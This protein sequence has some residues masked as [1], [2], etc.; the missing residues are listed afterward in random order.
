MGPRGRSR[1][2]ESRHALEDYAGEIQEELVAM[3]PGP[4]EHGLRAAKMKHGKE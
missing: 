1:K 2:R 4:Q 3:A